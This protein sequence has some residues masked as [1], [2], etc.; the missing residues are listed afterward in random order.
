MPE[1]KRDEEVPVGKVMT[2][3]VMITVGYMQGIDQ[4]S[5]YI[6]DNGKQAL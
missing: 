2:A 4:T 1:S 5:K 6:K 3:E